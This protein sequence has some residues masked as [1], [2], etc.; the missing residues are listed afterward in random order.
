LAK[1]LTDGIRTAGMNVIDI[2]MVDTSMIYFA[3]NHL[4]TVGGVQVTAS[5]NP[6]HYNGLKIS[7][8]KARPIGSASG[9]ND[10]KKIAMSLNG[11][12]SN[13]TG[14]WDEQNLWTEYRKH[15][16]QFLDLKRP[17]HVVIDGSNGMAGKM[18]PAVFDGVPNLRITPLL[19][20]I[21]GSF[22]HDP[23]PLV[24]ENLQMLR[25][26]MGP[27]KPDLGVCFDGDADRCMFLD[28]TGKTI[29]CDLVTALLAQD[30]LR[31]PKNKGSTIVY[32]LRSSHVVADVVKAEGGIPRRDRV[33]HAFLKKTLAG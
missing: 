2:G 15:V 8:P 13:P 18:V 1:A 27:V 31:Q 9:L 3:I 24:E 21:T 26:K 22:T 32:D 7:G 16:L 10:I 5:H 6:I 29:G 30:F 14:K 20:D 25:E 11:V 12:Q 28:E 23:N 17:I 19:F 33:G 4:D